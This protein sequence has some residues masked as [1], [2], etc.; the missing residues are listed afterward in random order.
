VVVDL[1]NVCQV[2]KMEELGIEY[3]SLGRAARN[4]P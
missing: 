2:D 4:L 1:R 3:H